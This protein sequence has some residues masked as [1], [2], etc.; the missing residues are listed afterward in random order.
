MAK[1]NE[2]IDYWTVID[3]AFDK[4]DIYSGARAYL[5]QIGKY[6][7]H[8]RHLLAAHWCQS[9]ICNGGIDQLVLN[10]TGVLAPEGVE[11]LEAIGMPKTA[12]VLQKAIAQFGSRYP[13]DRVLRR[14]RWLG[15]RRSSG[16]ANEGYGR[17]F[18]RL[19]TRFYAAMSA[20]GGFDERANAYATD[21]ANSAKRPSDA[22]APGKRPRT[23]R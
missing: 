7:P 18:A 20:E 21:A 9:E 11:G 6:P 22:K 13:R 2:P 14:A 17:A 8:V 16:K 3:E 23:K 1:T 12:A 19:D 15:L 10:S 4:V 5:K